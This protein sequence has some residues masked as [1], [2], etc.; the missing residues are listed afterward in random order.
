[1]KR[2]MIGAAA[3]YMSGLFFASF[4]AE[5]SAIPMIAALALV[6]LAV[7][8]RR[9]FSKGDFI[10]LA[11]T[12]AI[13]FGANTAYTRLCFDPVTAYGGMTGSFSGRVSDFDVYDRGYAVY[14]LKGRINGDTMAKITLFTNE[15]DASYGDV[16]SVQDCS[17]SVPENTYVFNSADWYRSRHIYLNASAVDGDIT[18]SHTASGKIREALAEFRSSA[19]E[20]FIRVLGEDSGAFLAGMVFGEK[21]YLTES[22]KTSLYRSG[23]GHIMAVSGLHASIAAAVVMT[24]LRRL[25]VNKY[26]SFA[27]VNLMLAVLFALANYPVSVIR[28][29]IMLDIMYSAKLLRQQN[30]P[31]NSLSAAALLICIADPYAVLNSGFIMSLSGTFGVAVFGPYIAAKLK[32]ETTPQKLY[33]AF[34]IAVCTSAAV[35]P[36]LIWY[37][38]EVSIISPVTN[39]LLVPLCTVAFLIGLADIL[40]F[41]MLKILPAAG[42]I[43]R[44]VIAVSGAAA[45]TGIAHISSSGRIFPFICVIS[46]AV[47]VL[48]FMFT[49]SRKAAAVTVSAAFM[50]CGAFYAAMGIVRNRQCIVA[51]LG[52]GTDAAAVVSYEGATYIAD[53]SGDHRTDEY[54]RKYLAVNGIVPDT[55]ILTKNAPSR[56]SAYLSALGAYEPEEIITVG[57][58]GSGLLFTKGGCEVSLKGEELT[59]SFGDSSIAILPAG[60]DCTEPFGV[61]YGKLPKDR[62]TSG[63]NGIFLDGFGTEYSG[64]N[65]FEVILSENGGYKVRRL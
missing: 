6:V 12:F 29:A 47:C 34:V 46:G 57:D 48:V 35:F 13:A 4:F 38:D 36:V 2:K 61:Y 51:V 17:F 58:D 27:A 28:A 18:V 3:A 59:V 42:L 63:I 33:A 56:Y 43:I 5:I 20:R 60:S 40:T 41:G 45:S 8:M 23:I 32:R 11:V 65:N 31:L 39:L 62:D 37:F 7:G 53:L 16:I 26:L 25:R 15:L 24:V 30:D 1:M 22:L 9:N 49:Y 55:L 19:C 10:M 50:I 21:D 44:P 64:T 14:T 52:E 54:V